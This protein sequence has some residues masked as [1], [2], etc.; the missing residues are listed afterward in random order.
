MFWNKK[1][2]EDLA[3]RRGFEFAC[4]EIL[5]QDTPIDY[6]IESCQPDKKSPTRLETHFNLGVLEACE[7]IALLNPEFLEGELT[8]D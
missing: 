2:K 7:I 6:V 8:D 5:H 3:Y 4:F 1:A